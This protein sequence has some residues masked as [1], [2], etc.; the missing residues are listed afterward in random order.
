V[1]VTH[2]RL[3]TQVLADQVVIVDGGRVRQSGS[4][5]EVFLRPTSLEVARIVGVDTILT[6]EVLSGA[7]G[8]AEV[9]IG[10]C[11]LRASCTG[12]R[13]G[14]AYACIRAEDVVLATE[15]GDPAEGNRLPG[16]VVSL[17]VEG[18][19]VR[20]GV[21]CGF[22]LSVFLTRQTSTALGLREG[23]GVIALVRPSAIHLIPRDEHGN[24]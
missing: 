10:G 17:G 5:D 23:M 6:I 9:L 11:R 21:D 1:L 13:P 7:Y 12:V 3:D 20:L 8:T 14:K 19:L 4:V 24:R 15:T 22:P 2:D 18:P 16:A